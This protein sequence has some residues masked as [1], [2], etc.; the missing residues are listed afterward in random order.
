MR[1]LI[2]ALGLRSEKPVQHLAAIDALMDTPEQLPDDTL[3]ELLNS[4]SDTKVLHAL[5]ALQARKLATSAK[6]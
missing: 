5:R 4:E 1:G 2:A 3:A 6:S